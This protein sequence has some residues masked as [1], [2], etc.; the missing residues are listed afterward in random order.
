ML[1]TNKSKNL[2]DCTG[3]NTW[4]DICRSLAILL[5]LASH[6]RVLLP[7]FEYKIL[8]SNGGFFGVELF[9]V[10]SGFL[11]GKILLQLV[12]ENRTRR[13][14]VLQFW[15]RRWYRTFPNYFLFLMLNAF[16]FSALFNAP[17]FNALYLVFLQ[18]FAWPMPS[19]MGES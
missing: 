6:G 10:L 1:T 8:L 5:V 11:I 14:D 3:R 7:D 9:F 2:F 17:P 12:D 4:L 18:N 15:K 19:L 13:S 16:V